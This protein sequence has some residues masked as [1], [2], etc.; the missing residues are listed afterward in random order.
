MK[1]CYHVVGSYL[2][3]FRRHFEYRVVA[4][5]VVAATRVVLEEHPNAD[6]TSIKQEFEVDFVGE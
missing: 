4:S 2:S 5:S 6:I 3:G 1:H